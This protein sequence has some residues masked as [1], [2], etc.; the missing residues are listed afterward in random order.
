M[1][2]DENNKREDR[3]KIIVGGPPLASLA[4]QKRKQIIVG[5]SICVVIVLLAGL[6]SYLLAPA[7]NESR[8]RQ[9]LLEIKPGD[10][11]KKI[12][13]TLG[14]K[15]LIRSQGA[16]TVLSLMTGLATSLKPGLYRL[17]PGM[18][19]GEILSKL[20]AGSRKEVSVTV[21]EGYSVYDIDRLLSAS[22]VLKLGEIV[23][24]NKKSFLEGR[25]FPDTY[26]FFTDSTV[27]EVVGKFLETFKS[28]TGPIFSG[29]GT[30]SALSLILASLVEKEVPDFEDRKIIA[31]I[32]KKRLEVGMPLQ[33]DATICYIKEARFYPSPGNCYPLS[34]LDFKIESP[35]NTYLHM[36]FPLGPIGNPSL[37]AIVA[38]LH[39]K[40]SP[41]WYYLSDPATRKTIFSRDLDEHEGNRVKYLGSKK[42]KKPL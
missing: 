15:G 10:G 23:E 11:Y 33:V 41:Y 29:N 28:K 32:L 1:L 8:Q 34:P 37:S 38:V 27:D 42:S 30:S 2:L 12:I 24:A 22:G 9:I 25:L 40:S 16:F 31:G 13:S 20:V 7:G 35:Y 18:T 3:K 4:F 19:S 6:F 26:R 17:H 36:G 39:P 14:S 21:I 5:G